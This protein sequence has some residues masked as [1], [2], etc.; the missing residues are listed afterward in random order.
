MLSLFL[1]LLLLLLQFLQ[2]RYPVKIFCGFFFT[3]SFS[4]VSLS[5]V[6]IPSMASSFS[7][8]SLNV[9]SAN[10]VA[11]TIYTSVIGNPSTRRRALMDL[12]DRDLFLAIFD[13]AKSPEAAIEGWCFQCGFLFARFSTFML[14]G[15]LI[16]PEACYLPPFPPHLQSAITPNVQTLISTTLS[17]Q[18]APGPLPMPV[19]SLPDDQK[20]YPD[21]QERSYAAIT[22][23]QRLKRML[24]RQAENS[25]AFSSRKPLNREGGE[26][27]FHYVFAHPEVM[28]APLMQIMKRKE[29]AIGV[30]IGGVAPAAVSL[31]P[32]PSAEV[33]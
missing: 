33:R 5:G 3:V 16:P 8:G 13:P 29:I 31:P 21:V 24:D 22:R 4:Q 17:G 6:H 18:A 32:A 28:Q 12:S 9:S 23:A 19:I 26:N 2:S 10:A 25:I 15:K 1:L 27:G 20:L 14:E 11:S 7:G 30:T